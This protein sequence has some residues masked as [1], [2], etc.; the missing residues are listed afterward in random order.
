MVALKDIDPAKAVSF[1]GHR[2]DRLP[3]YGSLNTSDAQKLKNKM[4]EQIDDSIRR[5]KIFYLHGAMAGFDIF[6]AE[7]VATM[8]KQYPQIQL[9]TIAPY[10]EHFFTREKCWTPDWISR[11]RAV[12]NQHDMG[13]K[14]AERYRS[15]IYYER[16]RIL[17]DHS[18]ELIC[19][20]DGGSGGTKYTVDQ[21][22]NKG[23]IVHNM[24]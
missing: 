20:W 23:I 7:Q 2:P 8:K 13:I 9:I 11:A 4:Q 12:F 1:S 6:A 5:G 18:S 10:K 19:Y 14:V 17:I 22:K 3:G 21:A 24:F 16:N 15:G